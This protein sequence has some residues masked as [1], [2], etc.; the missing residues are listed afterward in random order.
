[1]INTITIDKARKSKIAEVDFNNIPFGRI[2]SDHMFI[3]EYEKGE[4]KNPR[5]IPFQNLNTHP[6]IS[7]LHYGQSIFEGLKAYKNLNGVPVLFR[8]EKNI[9]RMNKSAER[10]AMPE[11]P[12]DLFNKGLEELIK[13]DHEWIPTLD[14]SSLYIRPFMF[15][16]DEYVGIKPSDKYT[17][18]IFTCPVGP[19]Y[20]APVKVKVADKYVRAIPGGVGTAKVAGNYAA[21]MKGVQEARQEGYDQILWMDGFEFKYIHEIGT[22]NVFFQI[23]DKVITPGLDEG[24]ILEGITRDS[25]ITLLKSEG[26]HVEERKVEIKEIIQAHENGTLKDVFGTGTA[27]TISQISHMGYKGKELELRAPEKRELSNYLQKLMNDIKLGRV[28][29]K[30]NWL[31]AIPI[32][33]EINATEE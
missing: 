13:L 26:Y 12:K 3:T 8:P 9:D 16:T 33:A 18:I 15:A 20:S 14:G 22:M 32:N 23:G 24:T 31:H 2:F 27:A 25:V 11:I 19:Y 4:W 21:T 1:M 28:E 5:I 30:F 17:F 10:M 7:A 6:A 29:D